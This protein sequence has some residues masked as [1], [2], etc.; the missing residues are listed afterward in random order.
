MH[1]VVFKVPPAVVRETAAIAS[2]V[3]AEGLVEVPAGFGDGRVRFRPERSPQQIKMQS[4]FLRAKRGVEELIKKAQENSVPDAQHLASDLNWR[5]WT[6]TVSVTAGTEVV[7]HLLRRGGFDW[8]QQG[9]RMIGACSGEEV[10]K[11]GR[12]R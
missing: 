9:L 8:R 10:L 11:W 7:C 12:S 3:L 1:K 6:V 5:E 2:D 4:E